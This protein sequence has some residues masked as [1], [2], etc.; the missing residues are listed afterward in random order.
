MKRF[1]ITAFVLAVSTSHAN[2]NSIT[3]LY[4]TG[5]DNSSALLAAKSTDGH[6]TL[7][8]NANYSPM[9]TTGATIAGN[10]SEGFPYSGPWL[11]DNTSSEWIIPGTNASGVG[12]FDYQTTFSLAGLNAVTAQITGQWSTDNIGI[13]I[14]LNGVSLGL[15]NTNQFSSWTPFSITSDFVAGLNTLDFIVRNTAVSPTGLRVEMSGTAAAISTAVPEPGIIWMFISGLCGLFAY[16][17][18]QQ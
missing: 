2:A 5:V 13:D 7:V 3:S 11:G 1:L 14:I 12:Y 16:K 8:S 4:N 17:R 9:V 6:Y 10:A 15:T 18:N